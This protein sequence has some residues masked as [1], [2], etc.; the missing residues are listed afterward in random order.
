V[1]DHRSL[2][3]LCDRARQKALRSATSMQMATSSTSRSASTSPRTT[4]WLRVG[5]LGGSSGQRPPSRAKCASQIEKRLAP[6]RQN[7]PEATDLVGVFRVLAGRDSSIGLRGDREWAAQAL[8]ARVARPVAHALPIR[9]PDNRFR[10][11][12]RGRSAPRADFAK[13]FRG[14]MCSARCAD[15]GTPI[16]T[17]LGERAIAARAR[18]RAKRGYLARAALADR[19]LF[20][21]DLHVLSL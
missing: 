18:I 5:L 2:I 10:A 15:P 13:R 19:D 11:T 21:Q 20:F 4:E 9:P 8:V 7:A 17:P 12:A 16:G 6:K 14:L 3:F 1:S